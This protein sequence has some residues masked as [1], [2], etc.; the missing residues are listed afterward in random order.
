MYPLG[1]VLLPC[2]KAGKELIHSCFILF[3]FFSLLRKFYGMY[4]SD[5]MLSFC[6]TR[7][8]VYKGGDILLKN[9]VALKIIHQISMDFAAASVQ[10]SVF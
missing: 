5:I 4:I 9:G 6:I 7:Y 1:R 8:T 10:T 3:L 2:R